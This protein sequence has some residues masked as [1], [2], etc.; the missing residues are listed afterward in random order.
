MFAQNLSLLLHQN[1]AEPHEYDATLKR[2]ESLR[3]YGLLPRGREN[4]GQRLSNEQIA[5]AVIGF[6][7]VLSGWAGHV[8]LIIGDLRPVGGLPASF[9]NAETL[10]YAVASLIEGK[11]ACDCLI[12]V[13]LS[14]ARKSNEDEYHAH[15]LFEQDGHRRTASYVSK[16]AITLLREGAEDTYDY[17]KPLAPTTRQVVLGRDFFKYLHRDVS[18]SR[19]LNRPFQ[20]DWQEYIT[21]EERNE[22]H[23]QLGAR[24]GSRFMNRGVET[25]VI[26]PKEPTRVEF[27]NHYLVRKRPVS[28]A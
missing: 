8:S 21:E 20:T 28:P 7:P 23:R 24:F 22:F 12:H 25:Q 9:E 15:I 5:S 2:F 1:L 27:D 19:H 10:K 14:I 26:W 17:D 4:A 13:T 18:L 6:T 11:A 3:G 16:D